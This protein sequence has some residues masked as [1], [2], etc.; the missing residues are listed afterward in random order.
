MKKTPFKFDS[1]VE[2]YWPTLNQFAAGVCGNPV[3][4][5][6]LAA[7]IFKKLDE[8]SKFC[9]LEQAVSSPLDEDEFCDS[10]GRP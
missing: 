9:V 6:I 5:S 7:E 3:V 1:L 10:A 8:T 4:A 2:P